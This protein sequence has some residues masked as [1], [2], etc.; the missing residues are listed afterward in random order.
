MSS[1]ANRRRF[2]TTPTKLRVSSDIPASHN[3]GNGLTLFLPA[4]DRAGNEAA[5]IR[6]SVSNAR[7]DGIRRDIIEI[8]CS[9]AS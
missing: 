8:F 9:S 7:I 5:Q 6:G 1:S 4:D 2:A 3:S